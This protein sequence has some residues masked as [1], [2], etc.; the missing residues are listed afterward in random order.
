MARA[1]HRARLDDRVDQLGDSGTPGWQR[2]V[3]A[4]TLGVEDRGNFAFLVIIPSI[5][6]QAGGLGLPTAAT[7][8]LAKAS[9]TRGR[10]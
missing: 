2:D 7:Y 9:T 10:S 6:T 1:G 5:L 3:A 8:Y 4:R